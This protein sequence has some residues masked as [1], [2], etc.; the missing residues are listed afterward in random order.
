MT[1]KFRKPHQQFV[2]NE[3]AKQK[4]LD[5]DTAPF[6]ELLALLYSAMPSLDELKYWAARNPD[7]WA[8]SLQSISQAAGMHYQAPTPQ[9]GSLT[10]NF[11]LMP[12]SQIHAMMADTAKQLKAAGL[13]LPFLEAE[14]VETVIEQKEAVNVQ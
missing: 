8:R 12:D 10:V 11:H 5:L 13:T 14:R 6:R 7:K 2:I 1:A 3:G 4:L 9:Q